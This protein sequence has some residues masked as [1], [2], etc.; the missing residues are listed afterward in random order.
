MLST[1]ITG[2]EK[3]LLLL[4]LS[5]LILTGC[6]PDKSKQF[7]VGILSSTDIFFALAEGFMEGMKELGYVDGENIVYSI[8]R[9]NADPAGVKAATE[10]FIAKKVDLLFAFATDGAVA[11]QAAIQGTDIPLVFCFAGVEGSSL[12]E[13]IRK[14]GKNTTGVRFPGP[15]QISKR[16][17]LLYDIAPQATRVWIGYDKDYPNTA[18]AL[19]ALRP[20]ALSLGITL[21]E[22][23]AANIEEMQADLD[24]RAA[25][26]SPGIDAIILMPDDFNHS[27]QG[28]E[29]I[30]SFA[31]KQKIILGG[32]FPFTVQNGAVFG[33][34][35]DL[36]KVGKLAAPLV[37]KI[38]KGIP[39]GTIP[40]VTPEDDIWINYKIA[41]ELGLTIPEGLLTMAVEVYH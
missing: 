34:A 36:F 8:A 16:L 11:S 21:V 12:I 40:V 33:N 5:A 30:T 38:F 14:P 39:A 18:P 19:K 29:M 15:E 41:K 25:S 35:N 7:H 9:L 17:E 32:S 3:L 28:L 13:S 1:K 20:L 23:P 22:A 6:G 24:T 37:D 4:F 27:P 31:A 2:I 26:G 10:D